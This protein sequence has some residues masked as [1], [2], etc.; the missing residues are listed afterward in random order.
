MMPLTIS[1]RTALVGAAAATASLA[2]SGGTSLAAAPQTGGIR[3][4]ILRFKRGSF[5]VSTILDGSIERPNP[6]EIFGTD[7][8]PETVADLATAN[9]LP[10]DRLRNDYTPVVV[11]TGNEVVLFDTGNGPARRPGRGALREI[12]SQNGI[13]PEAVDIVVLTHFHPDHIGGLFEGDELAFPNARYVTGRVEY[14]FWRANSGVRGEGLKA[15]LEKTVFKLP[16]RMSFIEDGQDVVS[17]I[18]MVGAGGHSPGH[19]TFHV[20]SGGERLMICADLCNHFVLSLQRP[21][22]HVRFDMDKEAAAAARR[23]VL[24]MIAADQIPFAGYHMP[25]PAVGFLTAEG[26][27]FRYIPASYQL[28]G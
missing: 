9:L 5:E 24:G 4:S 3:P 7:Q 10:A 25:F 27:G 6:H 14:D 20:E 26:R 13:A 28:K 17:G 18:T 23:N 21:D 2:V 8:L 16:D 12:L 19:A 11:N 1:R 22:W 15:L